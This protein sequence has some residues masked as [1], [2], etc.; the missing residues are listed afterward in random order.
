[1][2][3]I[4]CLCQVFL[5]QDFRLIIL[6]FSSIMP[7]CLHF[8]NNQVLPWMSASSTSSFTWAKKLFFKAGKMSLGGKKILEKTYRD[9]RKNS[10]IVLITTCSFDNFRESGN[11]FDRYNSHTKRELKARENF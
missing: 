3:I 9:D 1:M 2:E 5:H 4:Q 8:S 7:T 11:N 6:G 10:F